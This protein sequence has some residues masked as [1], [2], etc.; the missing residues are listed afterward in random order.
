MR[1]LVCIF[2]LLCLPLHTFA[3]QGGW[4]SA[5]NAFDIAHEIEHLQGES[6]H[7]EDDGSIH[8]DES[9]ESTQHSA[10]H[11][12]CQPTASLPSEMVPQLNIEPF[13]IA[14]V[15]LGVAVPERF[16]ERPQRP[17]SALG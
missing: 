1:R 15:S 17:P 13:S 9:T 8:Y 6:H 4:L 10:D 14:I 2:L 7:H 5:G 11:A 3:M 12:C 16:P